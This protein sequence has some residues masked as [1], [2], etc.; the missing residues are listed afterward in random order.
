MNAERK[1]SFI[2][3]GYRCN[4]IPVELLMRDLNPRKSILQKENSFQNLSLILI[5]HHNPYV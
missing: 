3:T 2:V 5:I 4:S 1:D